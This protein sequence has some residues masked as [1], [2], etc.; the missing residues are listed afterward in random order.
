MFDPNGRPVITNTYFLLEPQTAED[1]S[2][3]AQHATVRCVECLDV[4]K[5]RYRFRV[6]NNP[7]QTFVLE[8]EAVN[9][10]GGYNGLIY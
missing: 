4:N 1:G 6:V 8:G 10:Q 5:N 7:T 2:F 9:P 3:I